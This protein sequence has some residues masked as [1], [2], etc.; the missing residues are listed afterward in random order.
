MTVLPQ[1]TDLGGNP[2]D[3]NADTATFVHVTPRLL[4]TNVTSSTIVIL[5]FSEPLSLESLNPNCFAV[6]PNDLVILDARL[7]EGKDPSKAIESLE[8]QLMKNESELR[9]FAGL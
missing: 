3:P 7:P 8:R 4:N 6:S 9:K 2:V 5:S 1:V